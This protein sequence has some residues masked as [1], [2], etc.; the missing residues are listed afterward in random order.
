[1][2]ETTDSAAGAPAGSRR[3]RRAG[4]RRAAA[5][6]EAR[7]RTAG[8]AR[9]FAVARLLTH[10]AEIA[11]AETAARARPVKVSYGREGFGATLTLLCPGP[12][13]P[14]VEMEAP[15]I[16]ERVNACYGYGAISR[17]R[18]TQTAPEGFAEARAAFEPAPDAAPGGAARTGAAG[19]G[20]SAK[21]TARAGAAAELAGGVA[22]PDL[23]AALERLGRSVLSRQD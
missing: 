14:L 3:G 16:R 19:P 2:S 11:G 23:R 20:R 18:I 17:I 9:G 7:V 12:L 22:D 5:L 4:F 1:M 21:E 8:E 10:W 13:A 6:V 15:R